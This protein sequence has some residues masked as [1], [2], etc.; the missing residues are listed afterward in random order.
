MDFHAPSYWTARR[1][2]RIDG[3]VLDLIL[4]YESS[5]PSCVTDKIDNVVVSEELEDVPG[6]LEYKLR[7]L[8][9]WECKRLDLCWP[10]WVHFGS[11]EHHETP[12]NPMEYHGTSQ[13]PAEPHGIRERFWNT[14]ESSG[15]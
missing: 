9:V 7:G 11:Q 8:P 1:L 15:C 5:N 6:N 14:A 12:W 2:L 13:S 3:I 10:Q 4:E